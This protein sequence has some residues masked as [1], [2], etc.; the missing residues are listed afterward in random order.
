MTFSALLCE[1]LKNKK[2]APDD[3]KHNKTNHDVQLKKNSITEQKLDQQQTMRELV[4]AISK[5]KQIKKIFKKLKINVKM[6]H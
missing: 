2:R 6:P 4:K 1:Q 5:K 3:K